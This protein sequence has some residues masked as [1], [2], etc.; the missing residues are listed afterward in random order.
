MLCSRPGLRPS[1]KDGLVSDRLVT[2]VARWQPYKVAILGE[3]ALLTP[4][5]LILFNKIAGATVRNL[6]YPSGHIF[7][8]G[9][10]LSST[11]SLYGIMRGHTSRGILWERAG[12]T[13]I[14][15]LLVTYGALAWSM[16]GASGLQFAGLIF[17]RALAATMRVI[18]IEVIRR[19]DRNTW[20]FRTG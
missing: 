4:L 16:F 6:P 5:V 14:A 11:M 3:M 7:L 19:K 15:I 9:L 1:R 8:L 12:Q 2:W 17:S 20:P 13:G 10:T 18:Q